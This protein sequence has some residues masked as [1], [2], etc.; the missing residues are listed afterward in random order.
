MTTERKNMKA[1]PQKE[2]PVPA[3]LCWNG[4]NGRMSGD[5]R[6]DCDVRHLMRTPENL[7]A[8]LPA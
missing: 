5:L 6:C 4:D 2:L 7:A 1:T 8:E 3:S